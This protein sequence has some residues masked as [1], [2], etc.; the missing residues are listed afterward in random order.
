M[1]DNVTIFRHRTDTRSR[2]SWLRNDG[3]IGTVEEVVRDYYLHERGFVGG[4]VDTGCVYGGLL[5]VLFHDVLFHEGTTTGNSP[6]R[7]LFYHQPQRGYERY[8]DLFETRL[9]SFSRD[10]TRV[11]RDSFARFTIHPS[12]SRRDGDAQ[13]YFGSWT[14]RNKA[15]L[16][17]FVETAP[18]HGME[19]LIREVLTTSTKG[20]NR[21]W[22]DIV[23]W[24]QSALL[25]S[26]VKA[27]D[28]L[29]QPQID[30]IAAHGKSHR[31]ELVRVLRIDE[32]PDRQ[33]T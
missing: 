18:E 30:W 23:V 3:T 13:R 6:L 29:S 10:R 7:S 4:L 21:G 19:D 12:I 32:D 14:I 28:E 9:V 16:V 20:V 31:I 5:W 26:E 24:N 8:R 33:T 11:F 1:S 27:Q 15:G 22:P 17:S 25:F 2:R